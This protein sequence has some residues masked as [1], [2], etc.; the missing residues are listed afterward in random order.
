VI[1]DSLPVGIGLANS[2]DIY[3]KPKKGIINRLSKAI[4]FIT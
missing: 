4:F 3:V 2:Y 1:K